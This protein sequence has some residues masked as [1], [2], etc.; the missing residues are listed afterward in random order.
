[1]IRCRVRHGPYRVFEMPTGV[2]DL[3]LWQEAVALAG[4]AVRAGRHHGRKELPWFV[5]ELVAT[6]IA[7]AVSIADG[8]GR[9]DALDQQRVFEQARRS[10]V[11][12]E[13][14]LAIGKHAAAFPADVLTGLASRASTVARLLAGFLTFI[15]RQKTAEQDEGT[16]RISPPTAATPLRKTLDEIYCA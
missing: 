15:E 13:T 14:H 10:L 6:A 12:F 9:G 5:D 7:T 16:R 8:Y 1:M 11:T 4:D 3:K 2:K